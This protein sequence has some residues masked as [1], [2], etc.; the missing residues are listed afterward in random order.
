MLKYI[1][2]PGKKFTV[3]ICLGERMLTIRQQPKNFK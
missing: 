3:V 2:I 1:L